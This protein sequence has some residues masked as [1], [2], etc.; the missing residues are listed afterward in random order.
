MLAPKGFPSAHLSKT[1]GTRNE[2]DATKAPQNRVDQLPQG[3]QL[4]DLAEHDDVGIGPKT[5]E[6]HGLGDVPPLPGSGD[7]THDGPARGTGLAQG[8]TDPVHFAFADK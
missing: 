6:I 1:L 5:A 7:M 8:L 3:L 4:D 2:P